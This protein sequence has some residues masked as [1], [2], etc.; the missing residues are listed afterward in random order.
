MFLTR[1]MFFARGVPGARAVTIRP[2]SSKNCLVSLIRC[3]SARASLT[4]GLIPS[5]SSKAALVVPRDLAMED[6][7]ASG[8]GQH[9]NGAVESSEQGPKVT[10]SL[11]H[12]P[13]SIHHVTWRDER[14]DSH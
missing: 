7:T 6:A 2:S 4:A 8:W 11:I 1:M 12:F 5:S 3:V 10:I 14:S 13:P 9:V